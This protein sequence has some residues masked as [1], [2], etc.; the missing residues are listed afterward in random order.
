L[1]SATS[2]RMGLIMSKGRSRVDWARVAR[3]RGL[4]LLLVGALLLCHGVFG[5][6]HL[7]PTPRADVPA[8]Q[9]TGHEHV[10]HGAGASTHEHQE[11]CHLMHAGKYFAVLLTAFVLGIVL[12]LL[13]LL[14]GV[15]L[16]SRIP[17]S[18]PAFFRSLCPAMRYP[19]RG[20]ISPPLLQVFRL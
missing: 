18:P 4:A 9:H 3:V 7:C 8:A 17:A 1:P 13:L 12:G 16:W 20:P 15:R 11:A 6:L 14:M 5:A 10:S 2:Y 19:P